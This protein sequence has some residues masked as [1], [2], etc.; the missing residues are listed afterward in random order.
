[1]LPFSGTVVLDF[2][3]GYPGAYTTM[4][5]GDFGAEV[6]RIDPPHGAAPGQDYDLEEVAA[7]NTMYRNKKSIIINLKSEEGQAVLHRLVK[8][9]DI[10]LEGFRPGVMDR[11]N[12]G[13]QALKEINPRDCRKQVKENFSVEKMVQEYEK[14][15]K[16]ILSQG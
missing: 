5:L 16:K 1:M 12:A 9:A 7:Y 8:K 4:F 6:I 13:Y 3:H 11:L 15:Y 14:V 2:A 10:L